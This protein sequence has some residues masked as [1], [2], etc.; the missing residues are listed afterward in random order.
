[1]HVQNLGYPFPLQIGAQIPPLLTISQ[2][3]GKFDG[4]YL[5]NETWYSQSVKCVGNQRAS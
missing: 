2:L 4:L 3:N 1:M 5:R